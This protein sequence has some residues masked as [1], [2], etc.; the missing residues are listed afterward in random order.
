MYDEAEK[1]YLKDGKLIV[2]WRVASGKLINLLTVEEYNA[3]PLGTKVTCI[4]GEIKTKS[5][6]SD[7]SESK[8]YIDL[9][10][11]AG[12]IAFGLPAEEA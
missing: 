8:N 12:R 11:R 10:T 6:D 9:D 2:P 7:D 3:L 5:A 4:D 1:S